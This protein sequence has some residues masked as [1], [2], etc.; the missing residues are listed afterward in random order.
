MKR[1]SSKIVALML[2]IAFL[3]ANLCVFASAASPVVNVALSENAA[4]VGMIPETIEMT[5]GTTSAVEIASYT[6]KISCTNGIIVQEVKTDNSGMFNFSNQTG[7]FALM[8]STNASITTWAT[9]VLKLPDNLSAGSYIIELTG[10]NADRNVSGRSEKVFDNATATA[11]FTVNEAPVGV[12]GVELNK[13]NMALI[14]GRSETLTATVLP[15]NATNKT[16]TWS[17]NKPSVASVNTNTG[18]VTA[19][20]VGEAIITVTTAD[21]RK[22]D[23]C[24]VTVSAKPAHTINA[25]DMEVT[26]GDTGKSVDAV[27][28][29]SDTLTYSVKSGSEVID[30][31]HSTGAL[32]IKKAGAA[33]VTVTAA[34]TTDYAAVTKNV[35]VTVNPQTILLTVDDITVVDGD[36]TYNGIPKTPTVTVQRLNSTDYSLDW[37]NNTNAGENTASVTIKPVKNSNYTFAVVTKNFS[38]GKGTQTINA[39]DVSTIV[40][41]TNVRINA[42]TNDGGGA[43]SYAVTS[44][45]DVIQVNSST[46]ELTILKAGTAVVTVTA[47]SNDNYKEA[48]KTVNVT[49]SKKSGVDVTI[50]GAPTGAVPYGRVF[51][52]TANATNTGTNGTW[53][54]TSSN[55]DVLTVVN[56]KVTVVGVSNAPVNIT[57]KYESDTTVGEDTV[58][59][60]TTQAEIIITVNNKTIYVGDAV[61]EAS[62]LKYTVSGLLHPDTLTTLPTLA[63]AETPDTSKTGTYDIIASGAVATDNYTIKYVNGILKI[64][65]EPEE[66][67]EIPTF[68]VTIPTTFVGANV[69]VSNIEPKLGEEITITV[70]VE[71]LYTLL[72]VII[73]G[74]SYG[75]VTEITLVVTGDIN[76]EVVTADPPSFIEGIGNENQ[77][78][79]TDPDDEAVEG[80]LN[81]VP[82][83]SDVWATHWFYGDVTWAW[84]R[85][86]LDYDYIFAP[87]ANATRATIVEWIWRMEGRPTAYGVAFNDTSAMSAAWAASAGIVN[88]YGNGKF[89]PDDLVTREQLAAILYRYA[90]YKGINTNSRGD[91]SKFADAAKVSGWAAESMQWAVGVSMIN[92]YTD[93]TVKPQG[94]A[95]RAELTALLH[96]M[97]TWYGI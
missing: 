4:T 89:G 72:D 40:G 68:T 2:C 71:R 78:P 74:Q 73:N 82:P 83:Y 37:F 56:G 53:T 33:V 14:V 7:I 16:V 64:V 59:I 96:R 93:G 23:S 63:Y 25:S 55:T 35:N 26:Y 90:N 51:T 49:V 20:S 61:P 19:H 29:T 18:E 77:K 84:N 47:K 48:T 66:E 60:I 27:C 11:T 30:V 76:V 41:A 86:L 38:I 79:D 43:L 94:N 70:E 13:D 80:Y 5:I 22:T 92:G 1:A 85:R 95:T 62:S 54:W 15:N 52:L 31:D 97:S 12:T 44:G 17:S 39:N 6:A 57:A 58:S 87:N 65:A 46:G 8:N 9:V 50:S 10:I 45:T 67:P 21:G 81:A 28:V 34:E 42:T 88:G 75:A 3:F 32:T 91:L 24:T 36:L 69:A